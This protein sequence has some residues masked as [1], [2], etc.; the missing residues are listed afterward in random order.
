MRPSFFYYITAFAAGMA[1]MVAELTTARLLAPYFGTS[2][3][4]WTNVIALVML[5]L[6]AGYYFGGR[7]ADKNPQPALYFSLLGATGLWLVVLPFFAPILFRANLLLWSNLAS[8]VQWGSLLSVGLLLLVPM[9]FLGM[10]MPFS[11]KLI[12]QDMAHLGRDSGRVSMVSTA[13]SLLGTF[14]PAFV[15]IPAFGSS[16]TFIVVGLLLLFLAVLGLRRYWV[17]GL[18]CL[19]GFL[20]LWAPPVFA[21]SGLIY[22][23]E[24]A[25]GHVFVQEK[26][27]GV[28]NLFID[29]TFGIQSV[30][31]PNLELG[32]HYYSYFGL[33]PSM[34]PPDANKVL[35]LGHGGGIFTRVYNTLYPDLDI[36][37]VE[38]DPA[39]TEAGRKVLNLN[40]LEVNIVH[41]DARAFLNAS[42]ET[43]DLILVDVYNGS[44]IP[45]H[46]ATQ[47][48]FGLVAEHLNAGGI[49]AMNIAST[50]GP[51]L[52]GLIATVDSAFIEVKTLAIP[53]SY[54]TMLLAGRE[55][56]VLGEVPE[57]LA[58]QKELY[59]AELLQPQFFG[60][61]VFT[62]DK[63]SRVE[64]LGQAMLL[65]LF[66]RF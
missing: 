52:D 37:G 22:D 47:E 25:Y 8:L 6:S 64:V 57:I 41:S 33:V 42:K 9:F 38:L 24:S 29:T 17:L 16:R 11:V 45:P 21:M 66:S 13:G 20:T 27:D 63:S 49:M 48:F 65:K 40:D 58:A 35:I 46:L 44:S 18:L 55:P 12:A 3:F 31:Q 53:N 60:G 34:L 10:I 1:V 4:V 19:G 56:F 26:R 5:A 51:F 28:R 50:Q 62:D 36:T 14:L 30:Y 43:Y 39:V 2:L 59:E 23:D 61:E 7:L 54:N 32:N 15:L